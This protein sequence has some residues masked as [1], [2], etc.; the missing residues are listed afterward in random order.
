MV[1]SLREKVKN[2]NEENL[3]LSEWMKKPKEEENE[4]YARALDATLVN[5]G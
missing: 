4:A 1:R 3:L 2:K 5:L